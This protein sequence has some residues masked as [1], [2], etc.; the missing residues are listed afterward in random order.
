M[1]P[2]TVTVSMPRYGSTSPCASRIAARSTVEAAGPEAFTQR[3]R[4]EGSRTSAIRSPPML[5]L[6]G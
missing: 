4:P 1:A 6:C 2:G 5:T 3:V